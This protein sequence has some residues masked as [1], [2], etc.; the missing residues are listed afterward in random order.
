MS[1]RVPGSARHRRSAKQ[2]N[3]AARRR[4]IAFVRERDNWMC[5]ICGRPVDPALTGLQLD[6]SASLDHIVAFSD[7]GHYKASNL[8]LAHS[9][10]NNQQ[11]GH[12]L[13][14]SLV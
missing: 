14:R 4:I 11:H 6:G 12:N 2:P 8:R 9:L 1:S 13:D 3:A 10:C 5:Q 7:G